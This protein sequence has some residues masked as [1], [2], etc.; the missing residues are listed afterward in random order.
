MKR[1]RIEVA[2]FE[3]NNKNRNYARVIPEYETTK[4]ILGHIILI[5]LEGYNKKMNTT[6]KY[7]LIALLFLMTILV[8]PSCTSEISNL[9]NQEYELK[10]SDREIE[11]GVSAIKVQQNN[12]VTLNFQSNEQG[13]VHLHGY[14]IEKPVGPENNASMSF[15]ATATGRYNLTFHPNTSMHGKNNHS[16]ET[17]SH[18][19]AEEKH[20]SA[21]SEHGALFESNTLQMQETFEHHIDKMTPPGKIIYHNHMSHDMTGSITITKESGQN[22]IAIVEIDDTGAFSP[23]MLSVKPGAT[24]R[25]VNNGQS[26]ARIVSGKPPASEHKGHEN[27]GAKSHEEE[28]LL[29][30]LEVLP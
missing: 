28:I 16:G 11:G 17:E 9:D 22:E 30:S 6:W 27:H 13:M 25:W 4:M 21:N 23:H 26:K 10:I 29:T 3:P 18:D 12:L 15:T 24:I 8:L 19:H 2:S 1:E 20:S 14:D 7:S 5:K